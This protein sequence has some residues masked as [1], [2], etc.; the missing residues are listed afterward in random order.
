VKF[1]VNTNS[2]PHRFMGNEVFRRAGASIIAHRLTA[3]RMDA[4]GGNFSTAVENIL[5]LPEGSV[6]IPGKPDRVIDE[7]LDLDLGGVTVKLRNMGPAHTP[8]QLVVE[9]KGDKLVYTGDI[10]YSGRL[11]SV[12]PDSNTGSWIKA[13]DALKKFGP[14]T[15]IPGHGEP[16]GLEAFDFPTRQYL[17]LLHDHMNKMVDEGVDAQDAIEQLDQSRFSGLVNFEQLSGRNASWTYLERE[18]AAFE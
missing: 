7:D 10:L 11:L 16:A 8:A 14:V 2:Q 18:A 12:M 5:E 9:I 1:A 4:Q 6:T 13:F 3:Q 17:S 15:F